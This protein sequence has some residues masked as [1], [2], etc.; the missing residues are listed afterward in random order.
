MVGDDR[1]D[2]DGAQPIDVGPIFQARLYVG[3]SLRC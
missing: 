1:Q 2:G 3:V